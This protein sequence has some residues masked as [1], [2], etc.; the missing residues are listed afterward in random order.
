MI[1]LGDRSIFAVGDVPEGRDLLDLVVLA[2]F[3][4]GP[5]QPEQLRVGTPYTARR[6]ARYGDVVVVTLEIS[7]RPTR[8]HGARPMRPLFA[9]RKQRC[10]RLPVEP[11]GTDVDVE[12]VASQ[13]PARLRPAHAARRR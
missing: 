9:R 1:V 7:R 5:H 2:F 8:A 10:R 12:N 11:S 6:E 4:V 13:S 3:R